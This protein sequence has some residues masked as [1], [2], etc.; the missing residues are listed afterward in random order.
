MWAVRPRPKLAVEAVDDA[1]GAVARSEPV[2]KSWAFLSAERAR[3]EA[4]TS[5]L[6]GTGPLAG[7]VT[8]V[9]DTFDT[10]DQLTQYGSPIYEGFR[11]VADAAAVALLRESGAICLG[12]TVTGELGTG[13][14][15]PTA[16][17]HRPGYAVGGAA[18]G[19]AA[20]VAAGMVD[21]ALAAQVDGDIVVAASCCGI[22][23]YKPTFG[24][25]PTTGLKLLSPSL[26]T[27]GWF[28]RDPLTLDEVRCQLTGR[29]EAGAL[30][31]PP[32]I[33]LVRTEQWGECSEAS[34]RAVIAVADISEALGA[35]VVEVTTPPELMGLAGR[36]P[37]L[38]AYEA[39]RCLVW[40]HRLR[41]DKLSDRLRET[42]DEGRSIGAQEADGLRSAVAAARAACGAMFAQCN[43]VL[44]PAVPSEASPVGHGPADTLFARLW[45]MLGL[46]VVSVPAATGASGMPLGVQ[47]VGNVGDDAGLLGVVAWLTGEKAAPVAGQG[48]P[49]GLFA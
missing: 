29:P 20:A 46:P 49:R 34:Q 21:L 42:L 17:P 35:R 19:S 39:A 14:S 2:V 4:A 30:R 3:R 1:L 12:K 28:S 13:V 7:L 8:G 6:H 41:R 26:T 47:L 23:G 40:E 36:H 37:R 25:V 24:T 16:N 44:T 31:G 15:A 45:T 9:Q 18:V 11:P 27:V 48:A 10:S 22:Y 38:L 32:T 33:G 43:A 5:E